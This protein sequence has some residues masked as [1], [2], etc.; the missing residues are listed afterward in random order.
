MKRALLAL[1]AA[2]L[3]LPMASTQVVAQAPAPLSFFTNYFV[4]GDYA[5]GGTSLWRKGV[6]WPRDCRAST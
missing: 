6:E 1:V 2:A 4:T 3:I 5:V